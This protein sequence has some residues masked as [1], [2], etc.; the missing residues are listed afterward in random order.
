MKSIRKPG[1]R[2]NWLDWFKEVE[3]FG[4]KSI[5]PAPSVEI[6]LSLF[7]FAADE[8]AQHQLFLARPWPHHCS[9]GKAFWKGEAKYQ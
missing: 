8:T 6:C 9:A 5:H 1:P 2:I 7:L 3:R 4:S